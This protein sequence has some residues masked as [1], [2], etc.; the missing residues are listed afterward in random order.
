MKRDLLERALAITEREY[1]QHHKE[2]AALL[3]DLAHAC[4]ANPRNL[5]HINGIEDG[6]NRV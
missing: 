3:T 1:G 4:G 5:R 2:V 6:R